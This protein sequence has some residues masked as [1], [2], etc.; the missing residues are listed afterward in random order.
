MKGDDYKKMIKVM[1]DEIENIVLLKRI[2]DFIYKIYK[3][4]IGL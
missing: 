3:K 1:L 4:V 2:Y